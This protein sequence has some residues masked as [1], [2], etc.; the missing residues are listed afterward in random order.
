MSKRTFATNVPRGTN[1]SMFL[2][3]HLTGCL[4]SCSSNRT[5]SY[6]TSGSA[7]CHHHHH[8]HH[9]DHHHPEKHDIVS[10]KVST[11]PRHDT[12]SRLETYERTRSTGLFT[13]V[14]RC[15]NHSCSCPISGGYRVRHECCC[16]IDEATAVGGRL[17]KNKTR[18][19]LR[20]DR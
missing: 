5:G 14:A 12:P 9:H 15:R 20:T 17:H 13:P 1:S 16:P 4:K 2:T 10:I 8:H 18:R 11:M 19:G 7:T 6:R 3:S